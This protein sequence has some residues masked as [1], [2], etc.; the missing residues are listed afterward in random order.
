MTKM[1]KKVMSACLIYLP[2]H[3]KNMVLIKKNVYIKHIQ[4]TIYFNYKCKLTLACTHMHKCFDSN[5]FFVNMS[6]VDLPR[7]D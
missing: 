7:T 5:T 6:I 2:P 4:H 3:F 1:E